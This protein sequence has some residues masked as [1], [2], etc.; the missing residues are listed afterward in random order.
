[1]AEMK[2]V[3]FITSDF[4][5]LPGGIARL[6]WEVS[7]RLAGHGWRV[8]V[9][10]PEASSAQTQGNAAVIRV[11]GRRPMRDLA[12]ARRLR[13][14]G[15]V[16]AV[17][18]AV[19]YPDGV[20]AALAG[21]DAP[22]AVWAHGA[23]IYHRKNPGV[24]ALF[25]GLQSRLHHLVF[26]KSQVVLANSHF[27]ER[28]VKEKAPNV[29]RV[30]V[31][32]LG[33]DPE[34]FQ[35]GTRMPEEGG[36]GPSLRGKRVILSVGRL[37]AYKG[38]ETILRAVA[39]LQSSGP[40]VYVLVGEGPY[41]SRLEEV[42][43]E[44]GLGELVHFAGRTTDEELAR[45]YQAADA[46]ALCSEERPSEGAVEG[47]GIAFLE[48][49]AS[50]L[51]VVATNSGGIPDAVVDGETGFL[52]PVGD[53]AA[54][55]EALKRLLDD[56]ALAARMGEAGRRRVLTHFNW[57]STAAAVS[58]VLDSLLPQPAAPGKGR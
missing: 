54:V 52:V 29:R 43:T 16:D 22:L 41:R 51:P 33:T 45:W 26:R 32:P 58:Q 46:F 12:M 20:V 55:S 10:A 36:I 57:D 5:P 47:F 6:C 39:Q 53:V 35:P 1:M 42:A 8:T 4:P 48:A 17:M 9:I 31:I 14:L 49:S 2:H 7:Q 25:G 50:G 18:C 56:S 3:A 30:A 23:E 13:R 34:F 24:R 38:Y 28:L 44:L 37:V 11:G 27:T 21:V 40:V 15:P 19:W